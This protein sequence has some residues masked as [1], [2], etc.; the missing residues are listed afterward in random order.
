V[1]KYLRQL[2]RW[3][4]TL[5]TMPSLSQVLYDLEMKLMDAEVRRGDEAAALIADDFVEFGG[6]GRIYKKPD[7]LAIMKRHAPRVSA[8]DEFTVRELSSTIALVTYRL[9]TE[10]SGGSPGHVFLRS[11][12][13][14][15]QGGKW[16][17]TFHQ[18]TLVAGPT[19]PA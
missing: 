2:G 17:V 11:S 18:A 16:R 9:R 3:R 8:L 12:I 1:Q 13:W 10:G 6:S 14:T 7:A 15:Q 4:A 5:I 19:E